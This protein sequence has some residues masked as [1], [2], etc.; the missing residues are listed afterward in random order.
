MAIE[1]GFSLQE[2]VLSHRLLIFTPTR[3]F[4]QCH[5]NCWSEDTIYD[6]F[7]QEISKPLSFINGADIP[8]VGEIDP[9]PF[10]TYAFVV[11]SYSARELTMESD[12]LNGAAG[13]L[14]VLSVHLKCDMLAGLPTGAFDLAILFYDPWA[15]GQTSTRKKGFP[16]WSWA[17]WRTHSICMMTDS[18][19][20]VINRWLQMQTYIVWHKREP[21]APKPSLVW[22]VPE[23]LTDDDIAYAT[24]D[25]GV[26]YGRA[27]STKSDLGL[28]ETALSAVEVSRGYPLLQFW[29]YTV[30]F[31]TL[32]HPDER[33]WRMWERTER[34][35]GRGGELC[36]GLLINDA[37]L[38][39][40][41]GDVYECILL[42]KAARYGDVFGSPMPNIFEDFGDKPI[43]WVMLI[44]WDGP[45][46]E[47]RG[48]GFIYE[49]CLD[50]MTPAGKV[51][52]EILLA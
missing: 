45:V 31:T 41:V 11:R 32:E 14:N 39:E 13:V 12:T 52:K 37:K 15:D 25:S 23:G 36:G 6:D 24:R 42:S 2:H 38:L 44:V 1:H 4:F 49:D 28:N 43:W 5:Q 51:W 9:T 19:P 27:E 33:A 17:G 34:I 30:Q 18:P 26:P 22:N 10:K 8:L 46:A 7:P 47:R 29:A 20:G 40:G 21:H 16:S 3:I 48:L 50:C 35:R